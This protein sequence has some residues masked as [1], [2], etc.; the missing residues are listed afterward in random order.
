M[1]YLFL[2]CSPPEI[3]VFG[4]M[5]TQENIL[6]QWEA[7][8]YRPESVSWYEQWTSVSENNSTHT[9]GTSP[10][11]LSTA[12]LDAQPYVHFFTDAQQI[13]VEGQELGDI[14]EPISCPIPG[15]GTHDITIT[16]IIID[17]DIFAM[18]CVVDSF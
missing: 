7:F 18:D 11:L 12:S 17:W 1:L 6:V 5:N 2:S 16:Y 14:I 13:T 9:L 3:S 10:T 4:Q 8:T 15:F